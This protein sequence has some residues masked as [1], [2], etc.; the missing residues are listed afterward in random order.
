[1]RYIFL[2]III[3]ASVAT[4][5]MVIKPRYDTLKTVK[6][7]V[8]N[9]DSSL[10]TAEKLKVSREE[11]IAKYNSI[12]KTDLDGIKT[13]LPDSVDNIR[14]II[15]LDS[16]ATKNGLSTLRSVDYRSDASGTASGDSTTTTEMQGVSSSGK[17]YGEF[18]VSFQTS[19]Q[20]KNFLAFLSD[21]EQNL[22]LV[23]VTSIDFTV[24]G[25]DDTAGAQASTNMSYKVTLKTYWLKK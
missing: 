7:D 16:L 17:S 6:N 12:P 22:R 11:L 18:V 23:D 8:T 24:L 25:N 20:Y 13:L 21:L 2:L 10:E 19:G 15:Q 9:Y 3:G 4:F 14:L 5:F 1:M